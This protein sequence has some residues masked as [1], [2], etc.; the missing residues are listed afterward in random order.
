MKVAVDMTTVAPLESFVPEYEE[1]LALFNADVEEARRYL[2]SQKWCERI[3]SLYLGIT[4]PGIVLVCLADIV[5]LANADPRVWVIVGDIPPAYIDTTVAST[6]GSALDAYIFQMSRWVD[7]V[8][9]NG[10]L[11]DLIPVNAPPTA[12]YAAALR[13]RLDL[14][15]DEVLGAYQDQLEK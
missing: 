7:A 6:P 4:V 5:P 15:R 3:E 2:A 14:L 10:E 13:K 11:A 8:E 12:D 1:D 9:D